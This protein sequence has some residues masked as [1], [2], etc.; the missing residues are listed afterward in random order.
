MRKTSPEAWM[1]VLSVIAVVVLPIIVGILVVRLYRKFKPIEIPKT[2]V[3]SFA[4]IAEHQDGF[5]KILAVGW[6]ICGPVFYLIYT[7]YLSG[8]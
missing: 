2:A 3:P 8:Y 1:F 7:T 6:A 4:T 5:F